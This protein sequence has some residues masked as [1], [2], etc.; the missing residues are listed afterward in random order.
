M[1]Y[2]PSTLLSAPPQ[3]LVHAELLGFG[4]SM[5]FAIPS[6]DCVREAEAMFEFVVHHL[7]R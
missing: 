7:R 1:R 3:H 2:P 4:T 6:Q 5:M